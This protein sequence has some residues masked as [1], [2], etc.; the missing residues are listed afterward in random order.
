MCDFVSSA[1]IVRSPLSTFRRRLWR[2]SVVV[3]QFYCCMGRYNR[4]TDVF[5]LYSNR[6]RLNPGIYDLFATG[7][8]KWLNRNCWTLV[9]I[10]CFTGQYPWSISNRLAAVKRKIIVFRKRC[11]LCAYVRE[12]S[13][14]CSR[15]CSKPVVTKPTMLILN[16]TK[17]SACNSPIE[18]CESCVFA[19]N[20]LRVGVAFCKQL[21]NVASV[22]CL[23]SEAGYF[24]RA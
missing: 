9:F 21:V 1:D 24:D 15:A 5:R 7:S 3:P 8:T 19:E 16:G 10:Q 12:K 11:W 2:C 4:N 6:L 17:A 18:W 22:S 20:M 14:H 23:M 13:L